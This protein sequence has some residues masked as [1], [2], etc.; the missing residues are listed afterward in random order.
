MFKE[1]GLMLES[2]SSFCFSYITSKQSNHVA[3]L[4]LLFACESELVLVFF[5]FFFF[6]SS[7]SYSRQYPLV[8][9][10]RLTL[11]LCVRLYERAIVI[12]I[13]NVRDNVYQ[14]GVLPAL[15]SHSRHA[16]GCQ[17]GQHP[18]SD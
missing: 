7:S 6:F 10:V 15:P 18:V 4:L 11:R 17:T 16:E 5:C 14:Y 3:R 2:Y 12:Y 1:Q 9:T 8:M 13:V